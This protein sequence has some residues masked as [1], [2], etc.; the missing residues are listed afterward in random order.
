MLGNAG[1]PRGLFSVEF[2]I[3]PDIQRNISGGLGSCLQESFIVTAYPQRGFAI[4]F[5]SGAPCQVRQDSSLTGSPRGQVMSRQRPCNTEWFL[6][7]SGK[8]SGE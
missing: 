3:R 7:H 4:V 2:E 1:L 8:F 5:H 6:V